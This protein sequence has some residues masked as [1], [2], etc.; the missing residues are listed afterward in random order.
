MRGVISTE[1]GDTGELAGQARKVED[2]NGLDLATRVTTAD[3]YDFAP[4]ATS[5]GSEGSSRGLVV[6]YDYGVKRN[7]LREVGKLGYAVKVVPAATPAADVLALR[8]AGVLLSNGPGDPAAVTYAIEIIRGLLGKVPVFGICLGHQLLALAVGGRTFK[9]KFG[10]RGANQPVKDLTTGKIEIT[11]QNHGFAVE[12]ASVPDGSDEG[13]N[14]AGNGFGRIEITH[15][16][17]NDD[18][19]EGLSCPD[20][21]AFSVQYHPEA[22]PGPND[23]K[24]LFARFDALIQGRP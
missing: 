10:H 9:L 23:A 12:A 2:M 16:N 1:S 21:G 20:V 24:Y 6:A 4:T 14:G 19:V 7:I 8:P 11:A 5:A 13:G 17:L 18:T 15:V 22:A 3:G